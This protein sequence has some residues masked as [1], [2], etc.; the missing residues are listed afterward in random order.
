MRALKIFKELV[1]EDF[2]VLIAIERG[3]ATHEHVPLELIQQLAGKSYDD[4]ECN[5]RLSR[6]H[7]ME[8]I[9]RWKGSYTGYHLTSMGYD[10]LALNAFVQGNYIESF[11]NI[12]GIG[13]EADVF[14]ALDPNKNRIAIK[15]H[16]LGRISFR[17]TKRTRSY[18]SDKRHISWLYIS[19]LSAEKEFE[20]LK[21]I[22]PNVSVPK[23]ITHNRHAIVM[24]YIPGDVL[25]RCNFLRSP[26]DVLDDIL[27]NIHYAYHEGV[28]HGDL[29]EYN[30]FLTEKDEV[31]IFD[32]PQWVEVSHE[33][34][35]FYFKRDIRNV[36]TYFK[37]NFG[38]YKDLNELL[39][40]LK[41]PP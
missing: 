2:R 30:I 9:K 22:Y 24:E 36:L 7:G 28:I 41:T 21:R 38:L 33:N 13:K 3:M 15:F 34:A 19:R 1:H 4:S 23:P 6:L 27:T 11:G 18:S 12:L 5:F 26:E 20:C 37:K 10:C 16:R 40:L 39:T 8:L 25:I 32:W 31:I 14:D 35:D 29:S 17:Q